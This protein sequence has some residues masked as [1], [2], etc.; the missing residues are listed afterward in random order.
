MKMK[1]VFVTSQYYLS[2]LLFLLLVYLLPDVPQTGTGL[3]TFAFVV[4]SSWNA[5]LLNTL[6]DHFS[7]SFKF[8]LNCCSQEG[9]LDHPI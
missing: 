6:M 4:Y 2:P 1:Y 9:L 7:I 3:M 5:V 8:L